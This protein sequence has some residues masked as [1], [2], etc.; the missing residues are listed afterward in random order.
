MLLDTTSS[1]SRDVNKAR[2]AYMRDRVVSVR[3]DCELKEEVTTVTTTKD[4]LVIATINSGMPEEKIIIVGEEPG[5]ILDGRGTGTILRSYGDASY[6][7]TA[8]HVVTLDDDDRD[9]GFDK[10]FDCTIYIQLDKD[11]STS[12]NRMEVEIVAKD[13]AMDQA[14]LKVGKNLSIDS[15]FI[16]DPFPGEIVWSSGYGRVRANNKVAYLSVTKGTLATVN[17][18]HSGHRAHRVT[19]QIF[20]GNSGGP[21]WNEEGK[22]VGTVLFMFGHREEDGTFTPYEG[23]YYIRPV[24]SIVSLAIK[25]QIFSEVFRQ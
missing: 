21:V 20:S 24:T 1:Q 5:K 19:S 25:N 3:R 2:T 9:K 14:I 7:S 10:I 16:S 8:E 18:L 17:V 22:L 4:K 23:A 6:I 15:E 13:K 12:E 11:A